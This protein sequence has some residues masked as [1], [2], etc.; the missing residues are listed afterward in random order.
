[1]RSSLDYA[2]FAQ[3]CGRSPIMR[4]IMRA[5]NRII[6]RSLP[7]VAAGCIELFGG[8]GRTRVGKLRPACGPPEYII[9]EHV[10]VRKIFEFLFR[11][12]DLNLR[13]FN[14][15]LWLQD[16]LHSSR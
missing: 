4:E 6:P 3:L 14:Q 13:I 1:M 8:V 9:H 7:E 5:H 11:V 2:G 16:R 10:H 15:F 12:F